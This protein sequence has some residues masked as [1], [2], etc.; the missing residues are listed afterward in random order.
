MNDAVSTYKQDTA[1]LESLN[2]QLETTKKS[3]T[4]LQN[5][6]GLTILEKGQLDELKQTNRELEIRKDLAE[7]TAFADAK[8]SASKVTKAVKA[9][10]SHMPTSDKE[11]ASQ[12]DVYSASGWIVNPSSKNISAQIANLQRLQKPLALKAIYGIHIRVK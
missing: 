5:K 7:K 9:N 12:R 3:I 11:I 8:E 1:E 6:G 4:E 2:G 10:F